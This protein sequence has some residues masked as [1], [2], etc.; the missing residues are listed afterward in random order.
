MLEAHAS[1]CSF[2]LNLLLACR[3][4]PADT[5]PSPALWPCSG[6]TQAPLPFAGGPWVQPQAAVATERQH[7]VF[8]EYGAGSPGPHLLPSMEGTV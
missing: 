6:S 7:P 5:S 1:H 8:L 2:S 4:P 3:A